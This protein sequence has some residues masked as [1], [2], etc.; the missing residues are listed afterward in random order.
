MY[1]YICICTCICMMDTQHQS[2]LFCWGEQLS[3]PSFEKEG[4]EKVAVWGNLKSF[5]H[6]E[7]LPRGL[8]IFLVKKKRLS[9]TKY[10]FEFSISNVDISL[11]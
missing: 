5:Y 1:I 9:V 2:S 10:G 11:F 6:A 4:L 7:Y 3:A 8:P